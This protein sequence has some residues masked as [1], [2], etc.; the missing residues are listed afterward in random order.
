[1]IRAGGRSRVMDLVGADLIAAPAR[2]I[3]RRIGVFAPQRRPPLGLQPRLE[4][5]GVERADDVAADAGR[6]LHHQR[7]FRGQHGVGRGVEMADQL[8][9]TVEVCG[10]LA[11]IA[12]GERDPVERVQVARLCV[13]ESG[14]GHPGQPSLHPDDSRLKRRH[15]S[16]VR[17]PPN[18]LD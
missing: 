12:G 8:G 10:F 14:F 5:Q 17:S 11:G 4:R 2:R 6:V 13:A 1:M 15:A 3:A 18:G 9:V 16:T 7:E